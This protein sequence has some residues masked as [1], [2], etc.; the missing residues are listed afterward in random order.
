MKALIIRKYSL[1]TN[2]FKN[3]NFSFLWHE[4]AKYFM[5]KVK[6]IKPK[7]SQQD[8]WNLVAFLGLVCGGIII[9]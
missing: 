8:T 5:V 3:Q 4:K 1:G 2:P 7:W 9:N 6:L